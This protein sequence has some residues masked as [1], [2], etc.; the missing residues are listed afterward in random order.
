MDVWMYVCSRETYM[1]NNHTYMHTYLHN[2]NPVAT[3]TAA[4]RAL[5]R[6]LPTGNR[7]MALRAL[8]RWAERGT[9]AVCSGYCQAFGIAPST[10]ACWC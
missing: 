1:R 2:R 5:R 10:P 4:Y 9:H 8:R 3:R 7:R 6:R